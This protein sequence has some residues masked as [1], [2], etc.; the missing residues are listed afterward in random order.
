VNSPQLL[1]DYGFYDLA[2]PFILE[3]DEEG[4]TAIEAKM[5]HA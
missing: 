1:E 4:F 5:A 2:I 3:E